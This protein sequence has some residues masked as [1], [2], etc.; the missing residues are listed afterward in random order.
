MSGFSN[1]KDEPTFAD[2]SVHSFHGGSCHFDGFSCS[3]FLKVDSMASSRPEKG[4]SAILVEALRLHA[5]GLS[6]LPIGKEKKPA[7][8]VWKQFQ[9]VAPDVATIESWFGVPRTG[10]GI[11]L[12]PVSGDLVVRDF[13]NVDA[14]RAWK[15]AYP[16]LAATLPTVRTKRGFHVYARVRD[17][18]V[19][20]FCDGELRGA[21]SYV[22][23]PPSEHPDGGTYRWKIPLVSLKKVPLL[24]VEDTGFNREWIVTESHVCEPVSEPV[25]VPVCDLVCVPDSVPDSVPV[26]EPMPPE[27]MRAIKQ[28]LPIQ[29]GT[30]NTKLFELARR[31]KGLPRYREAEP[32]TL[33][34][35]V[36]EWH[37]L[38]LT[39]IRTKSFDESW[40]DFLKAW[41]SAKLPKWKIC[42][43]EILN[44]VKSEPLPE[45]AKDY[46]DPVVQRLVK[47]CQVLQREAGDSPFI[48]SCR[49]AG[50]W[51]GV[52]YKIAN[53]WLRM[54]VLEKVLSIVTP[55]TETK[56]HRFRYHGD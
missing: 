8:K 25:S 23:A 53:K 44:A 38:A 43:E 45:A 10:L 14:Y 11:I 7:V 48:L 52:G 28:T 29:E 19:Q 9:T 5:M 34:P 2:S 1:A 51:L 39:T 31:L 32:K 13:D 20:R 26:S 4:K 49:K 56:A 3:P 37:R 40:M 41:N 18:K 21:G 50:E 12:G 6:V 42:P 46:D 22:V 30:R 36:R 15:K 54:L 17:R 27:V 33:K 35:I 47:L 16:M 55:G 24:K